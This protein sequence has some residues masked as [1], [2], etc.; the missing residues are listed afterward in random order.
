MAAI[1]IKDLQSNRILDRQAMSAIHGAGG[2][3]W[4]FGWIAPYIPP[5]PGN[6]SFGQVVNV[7][8]VTNNFYADQMNNQFQSINV[9]NTAA[10]STIA[11]NTNQV[12]GN[13]K[14]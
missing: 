2:A 6:A 4:V 1:V 10:N 8:E 14:P 13:I 9:N 5:I 12:A 7:F 11:V 3:P